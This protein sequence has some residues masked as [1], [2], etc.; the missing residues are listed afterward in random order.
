MKTGTKSLLFGVHQFVWHPITVLLAWHHL[1]GLPNWKEFVCIIIHDWGY[2]GC[3]N[4]DDKKGEEHPRW[5][6]DKTMKWFGPQYY[7]LCLYHSRHYAKRHNKQPSRL[8]WADKLSF[9]YDPK[10]FYLSRAWSSGELREYL[11]IA[12]DSGFGHTTVRDWHK[13]MKNVMWMLAVQKKGDA[14]PYNIQG[15]AL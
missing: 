10:W 14:T 12:K 11:K 5:A 3:E 9:L 13:K 6:A 4:M 8:C 7:C 2:W 1:C 15:G